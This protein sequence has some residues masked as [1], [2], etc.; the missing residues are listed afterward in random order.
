MN[1]KRLGFTLVELLVVMAM[2]ML[3]IGSVSSAVMSAQKR[4]KLTRATMEVQQI[5]S[6]ILAY[7][8]Y[9]ELDEMTDEE[10]TRSSMA[11]ILGQ[12]TEDGRKVPVLFNASI[13]GEKI[14]DPW[15]RPYLVTVKEG[16]ISGT[17]MRTVTTG[18]F[19]PNFY[20]Q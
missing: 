20:R 13:K 8:N 19:I 5:T 6:A 2:L 3:I 11:F 17:R 12:E 4:A 16:K 14:L 1:K 9:G 15:G 7:E 18:V 10:A